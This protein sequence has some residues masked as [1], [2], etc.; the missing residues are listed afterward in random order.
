MYKLG[1]KGQPQNISE[2]DTEIVSQYK[3][4]IREQDHKLHSLQESLKESDSK[5]KQLQ[6]EILVLKQ[7]N[8]KLIDQNTLY[9]AQLSAAKIPQN[10]IK[11]KAQTN[12][13][14]ETNDASVEE[15]QNKNNGD[16]NTGTNEAKSADDDLIELLLHQVNHAVF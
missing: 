13:L 4:I 8:S 11:H 2:N 10:E 6:D 12:G 15:S 14:P 5:N 16:G 9:K 7:K 1:S 3:S